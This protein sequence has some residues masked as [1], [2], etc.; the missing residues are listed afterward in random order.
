M[1]CKIA[2]LITEVPDT[3]G[4]APRVREYLWDKNE[5]PDIVIRES[6]FR[7]HAWKG[8]PYD[9]YCYMESGAVFCANLLYHDGMMLHASAVAY[10]GR[11]YLFSGSSG[12][13]KSTH[14]RLWKQIFGDEAVIINDDKPA[15]RFQKG[16]WYAYGSPWCGKE[17]VNANLK[18]P[19]AGIC[20][21][22]QGERN[23]ISSLSSQEAIP[24]VISQTMYKFK[25]VEQTQL[26]L[27]NVG[28]LIQHVPMFRMINRAD[29]ESV[30]MTYECMLSHARGCSL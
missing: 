16:C 9:L 6:E 30:Q 27:Q 8:A 5:L 14:T 4:L 29:F 28:N 19:I 18:V 24:L 17:G 20:F 22:E 2:D 26:M 12:V 7:P 21:L 25:Q 11:A 3:G 10:G 13:G 15:L 23:S 1:L